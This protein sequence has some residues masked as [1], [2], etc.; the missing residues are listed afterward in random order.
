MRKCLENQGEIQ[1][2]FEKNLFRYSKC[3]FL[4]PFFLVIEYKKWHFRCHN[5]NSETTIVIP[6]SPK[7]Y[8]IAICFKHFPLLEGDIALFGIL[9][10]FSIFGPFSH[11]QRPPRQKWGALQTTRQVPFD[12]N[13][14]PIFLARPKCSFLQIFD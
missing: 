13:P 14:T 1:E 7:N 5:E 11:Q 6:T 8:G 10:L 4:Y 12:R 9:S 2:I 3:D